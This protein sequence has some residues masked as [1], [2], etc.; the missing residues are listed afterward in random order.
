[1]VWHGRIAFVA[2]K[3]PLHGNFVNAIPHAVQIDRQGMSRL[4]RIG[5]NRLQRFVLLTV[6]ALLFAVAPSRA[7]AEPQTSVVF[8]R[9]ADGYHTF[10]IPA[11]VQAQASLIAIC[12]GRKNGAGDAG[13]IDVVCRRSNDGGKTWG[14]LQLIWDDGA[15]SCGNPC[16]VVDTTTGVIWLP[17]THNLGTDREDDIISKSS[18]GTRTV[19]MTHSDDLGASW[20]APINVTSTTKDESWTWY[21]TGP[22]AAIQIHQGPHRGRLVVPCDHMEQSSRRYG[23]HAIYS[24]DHGASWQRGEPTPKDDVNECEI[25]EL[26]DGALMINMRNYDRSIPARQVAYSTDGGDSWDNQRHDPALIEPV[27][28]ASIRRVRWPSDAD[29]GLILFTNPADETMRRN[30]TLRGS[31]D[32][33]STWPFRRQLY[34]KSSAYSCLVAIDET[35]AGCLYE[36][37]DYGKI[38]FTRFS[39]DWIESSGASTAE[40]K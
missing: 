27:C 20:T 32:D 9:G 18:R 4:L 13:D 15:N 26:S 23:S 29:P 6:A 28:Q 8:E 10:R 33:G 38:V 24:D 11:I 17:L 16:P 39:L 21:A 22:G 14:P 34:G 3:Q 2:D 19:W 1:M 25:V 7:L 31:V 36:V 30:L 35:S 12:E 37:D 40:A 5:E